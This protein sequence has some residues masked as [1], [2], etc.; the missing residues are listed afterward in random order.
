MILDTLDDNG[1]R[2]SNG[3]QKAIKLLIKPAQ[4]PSQCRQDYLLTVAEE[5]HLRGIPDL[6]KLLDTDYAVLVTVP[7]N[8]LDAALSGKDVLPALPP[9]Q[10]RTRAYD[11]NRM[12][13]GGRAW[14]CVLCLQEG[15][16][17]PDSF[18]LSLGICC[19]THDTVLI[20]KCPRCK[21]Q[22][23][24]QRFKR[25]LCPCGAE[26]H[27]SSP[28]KSPAWIEDFYKLFAPWRLGGVNAP[29]DLAE[30]EFDIARFLRGVL[31]TDLMRTWLEAYPHLGITDLEGLDAIV[32]DWPQTFKKL[33]DIRLR[34]RRTDKT[35]YLYA[36]WLH[37]LPD[38][39]AAV[40]ELR[41]SFDGT[42]DL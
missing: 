33:L 1:G 20:N 14:T 15:R 3:L 37:L 39:E 25:R 10:R 22:L 29:L 21:K 27:M 32:Q 31:T 34:L 9:V 28:I 5:N 41:A 8:S 16:P 12:G 38:V 2:G 6:C 30:L 23:Y 26:L 18:N 17:A 42:Y 4:L 40:G 19:H 11:L 35:R 13:L 36:P 7:A 24:Y